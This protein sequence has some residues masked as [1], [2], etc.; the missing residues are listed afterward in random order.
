[1]HIVFARKV[2][3]NPIYA[4]QTEKRFTYFFDTPGTT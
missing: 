4:T 3:H 2:E 1:M